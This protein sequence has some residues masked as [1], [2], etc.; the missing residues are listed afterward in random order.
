[1][2]D[3][4]ITL[5]GVM[6]QIRS[7][8]DRLLLEQER[9]TLRSLRLE[10][11]LRPPSRDTSKDRRS[12][13]SS[14]VALSPPSPPALPPNFVMLPLDEQDVPEPA[15]PDE[16][17]A[18]MKTKTKPASIRSHGSDQ[19]KDS[20]SDKR[21][22]SFGTDGGEVNPKASSQSGESRQRA[23]SGNLPT[24]PRTN[25][26]TVSVSHPPQE[27]NPSEEQRDLSRKRT[28]K[29]SV[30]FSRPLKME[31]EVTDTAVRFQLHK[32]WNTCE[33]VGTIKLSPRPMQTVLVPKIQRAWTKQF[34]QAWALIAVLLILRDCFAIPLMSF[35]TDLTFWF[36][37]VSAAM[38]WVLNILVSIYMARYRNTIWHW[39]LAQTLLEVILVT[40]TFLDLI[41]PGSST[42]QAV[43]RGLQLL[44]V[45]QIPTWYHITGFES[46]VREWLRH[47]SR[48]FRAFWNVLWLGIWG[49]L[50]LH[51]LT[52]VW[53]AA[54][55]YPGRWVYSRG[56]EEDSWDYQYRISLEWAM[57]RLP[58]SRMTENMQLESSTEKMV[59]LMGTGLTMLFGS[60]FTSI[61]TNDISDIRRQRRQQREAEYQVSDY[62]G[63]NP[64]SWDLQVQLSEYLQRNRT[65]IQRPSKKEMRAVLPQFLYRELC[66]E[67][68]GP[69]FADHRFLENLLRKHSALQYEL[70]AN[71]LEEVRMVPEETIFHPGP[72]CDNMLFLASGHILYWRQSD[73]VGTSEQLLSVQKREK[74][75]KAVVPAGAQ[76]MVQELTAGDWMCEPCLWTTWVYVGK[77]V[78]GLDTSL[79]GLCHSNLFGAV[80]LH[81]SAV[82][83]LVMYARRFVSELND[84]CDDDLTDVQILK[85]S[86]AFHLEEVD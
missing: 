17:P 36:I 31:P 30:N 57:A 24:R 9:A 12:T 20:C 33:A 8:V 58:P 2:D 35:S 66:R 55:N 49:S 26:S 5:D 56:M 69:I 73:G 51:C 80:S 86:Q 62:L 45:L 84:V 42:M 16:Q 15:L 59:S 28:R 25:T 64:V 52:C 74:N 60:I 85:G 11:P 41:N 10:E 21:F 68:L 32:N 47:R 71:C 79:V 82:S 4:E 14:P 72:I 44:R 70:C 37:D 39:F 76:S 18:E 22:S 81:K 78:A 27:E 65:R 6:E 46:T 61:V 77:A 7:L 23:N 48:E 63:M 53:F 19:K 1:M 40:P 38:F 54:G 67:A 29:L 43:L 50:F 3:H 13:P 75:F 34:V 83:E